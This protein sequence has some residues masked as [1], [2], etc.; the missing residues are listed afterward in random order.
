MK[1]RQAPENNKFSLFF[2]SKDLNDFVI[3]RP[4]LRDVLGDSKLNLQDFDLLLSNMSF[5]QMMRSQKEIAFE[6]SGLRVGFEDFDSLLDAWDDVKQHS[7]IIYNA[8]F[9]RNGTVSY[10]EAQL[11]RFIHF[12]ENLTHIG[13]SN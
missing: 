13:F 3:S 4:D 6:I 12:E 7:E 8:D 9:D 11:Y 10:G 5:V 1:L 2:Q